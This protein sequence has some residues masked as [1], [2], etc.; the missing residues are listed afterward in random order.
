MLVSFANIANVLK[1]LENALQCIVNV[2]KCVEMKKKNLTQPL[3]ASVKPAIFAI[4]TKLENFA[5]NH[6]I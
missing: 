5:K 1:R 4:S 2:L 6:S 3:A